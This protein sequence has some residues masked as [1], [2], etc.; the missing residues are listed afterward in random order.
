MPAPALPV[1]GP[2]AGWTNGQLETLKWIA[3]GSMFID[4]FGRLLLGFGMDTWV[5]AAGRLAFPLFAVVL[6]LNLARAGDQARRAA[7]TALRLAAW[8]L[9]SVLPSVWARGDALL[10]NV[11]G[12]LSLGAAICW[13]LASPAHPVWR[14]AVLA[15]AA[16]AALYVEFGVA[17][18]LLVAGTY[19][20]ARFATVPALLAAAAMLVLVGWNNAQFGGLPAWLGTL[21]AVPVAAAVRSLPLRMPRLKLAFYL[22]YPVHLALIG[23]L[24]EA[25]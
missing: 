20:A 23:A 15:G 14:A 4:H 10:V 1:H 21:S 7:R 17:G 5:F 12:T 24:R 25:G 16:L 9:V 13:A 11:L 18:V 6:G 22:V 2:P 3:L 8:C 19:L